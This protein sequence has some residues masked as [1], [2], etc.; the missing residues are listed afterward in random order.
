MKSYNHIFEQIID[1]DNLR[2]AIDRSSL[3]KRDRSDVR[4]V[5]ENPEPHIEIIRNYLI[6][7]TYKIPD[8][9]FVVIN[10]GIRQKKRTIIKPNYRYEQIIHH[11]IVQAMKPV[12]MC[13]MYRYSCGSI[14]DRGAH[15][16]KKYIEKFIRENPGEVKYCFKMDI[17]HFFQ[18]IN[19]TILKDK[20]RKTI[21]DDNALWLLELM[22]DAYSDHEENDVKYGLPLGYYT[23]Q[24][25]SNWYLQGLDHYIKENLG[26]KCFVRYMDD[27][28]IFGRNKKELHNMKD[29]IAHYL[30]TELDLEIKS[31]WQVFRFDYVSRK[32]GK[33]KGRFLDFMGFRFYRDRTTLRKS[34]MLKGTRKARAIS[35]KDK[36]TWF[37]ACQMIS[38]LGW[39]RSVDAYGVY[40]KYIRDR[41]NV[42]S[43]KQ[44]V[45]RKGARYG[46]QLQECRRVYDTK[47]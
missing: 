7:R 4:R 27:I 32:D 35:K 14:P 15:F 34:I 45:S 37:D 16:G 25:F 40:E 2:V 39:F 12:F 38:Y 42:K 41:I 44:K 24:W 6:N 13:G 20:F 1:P 23:S 36:A 19:Q 33:R 47:T 17:R 21:H 10:D 26:A 11:A 29:K 5:R 43:L 8:H 9:D 30:K 3:G 22:I 46:N 31:N 18:S 28:I